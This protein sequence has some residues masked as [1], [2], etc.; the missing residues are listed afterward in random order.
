MFTRH[1]VCRILS[2][3]AFAASL[4]ACAEDTVDL[5]TVRGDAQIAI[6]LAPEEGPE[7]AIVGSAVGQNLEAAPAG[8]RK[9]YSW[10]L[11]QTPTGEE[12]IDL[13][14]FGDELRYELNGARGDNYGGTDDARHVSGSALVLSGDTIPAAGESFALT[15]DVPENERFAR[16]IRMVEPTKITG[17]LPGSE[18]SRQSDVEVKWARAEEGTRDWVIFSVVGGTGP[19]ILT[20]V[21]QA[22]LRI[23][24]DGATTTSFTGAEMGEVYDAF[25]ADEGEVAGIAA[26]SPVYAEVR[27]FRERTVSNEPDFQQ[28]ETRL[29]VE[30]ARSRVVFNP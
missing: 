23:N 27:L 10:I 19:S 30:V 28:G 3:A 13:P 14:D 5:S 2:V 1:A 15:L 11:M 6:A 18:L 25:M 21:E 12:P 24:T 17:P 9:V 4:A 26:G 7:D 22:G 16:T 8:G 20:D 29:I